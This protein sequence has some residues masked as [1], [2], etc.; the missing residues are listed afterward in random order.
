MVSNKRKS[1]KFFALWTKNEAF[2]T[3]VKQIWDS[4]HIKGYVMYQLCKKLKALKPTLKKLNTDH[5]GDIQS[6]LQLERDK[7]H[8]LRLD[9]LANSCEDLIQ[10]EHEQAN[11][12]AALQLAEESFFRQQSRVK[13]LQEGDSNTAYFHQVV[14]IKRM[15]NTITELTAMDGRKL[16]ALLDMEAEVVQFYK[17][18]WEHK[19]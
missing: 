11:K 12:V 4:T 6:R 15:K 10:V 14:K 7:L 3:T 17:I 13:W 18:C 2:L 19:M 5:Y 9:L 1:F 8:M 16:T